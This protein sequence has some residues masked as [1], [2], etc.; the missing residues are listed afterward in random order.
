MWVQGSEDITSIQKRN[1][2]HDNIY[3]VEIPKNTKQKKITMKIPQNS[4]KNRQNSIKFQKITHNYTKFH[5]IPQN[6]TKN[7]QNYI[8]SDKKAFLRRR[9]SIFDPSLALELKNRQNRTWSGQI[10]TL[11]AIAYWTENEKECVLP[12]HFTCIFQYI[13]CYSRKLFIQ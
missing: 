1:I 2:F 3:F 12:P 10:Q 11:L 5:K 9:R 13:F 6:S 8:I 7:R 4:I